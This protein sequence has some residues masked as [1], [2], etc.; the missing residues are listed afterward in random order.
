MEM[1]GKEEVP[2]G[3]MA[4]EP[5]DPGETRL[6]GAPE[7]ESELLPSEFL[8]VTFSWGSLER[9]RKRV[10]SPFHQCRVPRT[11]LAKVRG[12]PPTEPSHLADGKIKSQ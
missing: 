11:Q 10:N 7:V 8:G 2:P 6:L 12:H 3:A 5:A 1:A 4:A 9:P